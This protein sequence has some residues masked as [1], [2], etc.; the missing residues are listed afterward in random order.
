MQ[1]RKDIQILRGVSVLLVV[2]FHLEMGPFNSGFL[3]VDVFFVI[4]GYLM[5]VLYQPE[6]K[7]E[8]FTKRA[9]RLLPA[10]FMVIL[11]VLVLCMAFTTPNDYNSVVKQALFA[12]VFSSNIGY[13]MENSYFSKAAFNPLLHLWS[14]GVEIQFYLLL[15]LLFKIFNRIKGSYFLLLLGSLAACF[16]VVGISPKTSFFMIPL[17]LW[18]FLI[19]YGIVMHLSQRRKEKTF[20]GSW[21]GA[22]CL[23]LLLGIPMINVDGDALGFIHG[24]PGISALSVSMATGVVL[25]AGLPPSIEKLRIASVLESFGQYSYSIYLVHFPV[26]VIFLY[27]PFSG[28]ILKTSNSWQIFVLVSMIGTLSVL[29]YHFIEAPFRSDKKILWRSLAFAMGILILCPIGR[30][31]NEFRIPKQEMKIYEA[32]TDRAEYR[33]GKINRLID[34]TALSCEIT[35]ALEKP[36]HRIL[37]VGNSHADSIKATFASVAQ[38]KNVTVRFMV[39]N[40]PLMKGGITPND[41]IHEAQLR[42]VNTIVLHYSPRG[43]IN[44][45]SIEQIVALAKDHGIN[46]AFIMPVPVWQEHIPMALWNHMEWNKPLPSTSLLDYYNFNRELIEGLLKINHKNFKIYQ[47]VDYFCKNTCAM[48]D[49]TGKPLYFDNGHLTLT[50]SELL[51]GIFEQVVAN[52][53]NE[54]VIATSL[55]PTNLK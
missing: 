47:I 46:V 15:P 9:K 55:N 45:Y 2:L 42:N 4:S 3:G 35:G 48:V 49:N 44:L 52:S 16:F 18:E 22:A 28:T 21:A 7:L 17:R 54:Q 12:I 41:L 33:C 11:A 23:L 27:Q 8:F 51:R 36:V 1:Y 26:I 43:G 32:W 19:G 50:G 31:F 25:A 39:E 20:I 40:E 29:M 24:H 5:A 38:R 13:W 30:I 37:L 34:P 10:Y 14:L 6:R 53:L